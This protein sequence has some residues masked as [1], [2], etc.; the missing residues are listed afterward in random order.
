MSES[1]ICP[2]C[3]GTG[4]LRYHDHKEDFEEIRNCFKCGGSG[5]LEE[6]HYLY[7]SGPITNDPDYFKKFWV[8]QEY[9]K[10]H[11]KYIPINSAV[12]NLVF[13]KSQGINDPGCSDFIRASIYNLAKN[14]NTS[15]I[16]L[17]GYGSS[18]GSGIEANIAFDLIYY[19]MFF[20]P[21]IPEIK[22]IP[23]EMLL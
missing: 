10:N 20:R 21:E 2:E 9:I 18:G 15:I 11:T 1:K 14:P 13:L 8:C 6:K 22:L 19:Q 5:K 12:E 7:I 4:K 16:F 17:P 3:K 23:E